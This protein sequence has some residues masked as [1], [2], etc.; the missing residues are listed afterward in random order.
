MAKRTRARR[1]TSK[2][3]RNRR[4]RG[5]RD[6]LFGL[7]IEPSKGYLAVERG[8]VVP[9]RA[10]SDTGGGSR[11]LVIGGLALIAAGAAGWFIYKKFFD[12]PAAGAAPGW[13]PGGV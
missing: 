8:G 1:T 10:A 2:R 13:K 5:N 9:L 7:G 6:G 11:N 12:A 3:V 4:R